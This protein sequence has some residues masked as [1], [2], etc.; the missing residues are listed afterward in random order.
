M[1]TLGVPSGKHTKNFGKS[2]CLIGKSTISMA[3][4]NDVALPEGK[5]DKNVYQVGYFRDKSKTRQFTTEI[6]LGALQG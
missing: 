4:F 6:I 1:Y 2:P 3:I 5:T